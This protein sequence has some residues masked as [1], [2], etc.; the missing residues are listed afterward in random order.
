MRSIGYVASRSE[1]IGWGS[2]SFAEAY[3]PTHCRVLDYAPPP[4][5]F[6]T[7][8]IRFRH[9]ELDEDL[10]SGDSVSEKGRRE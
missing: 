6:S 10:E 4:W 7:R 9:F 5:R 8:H 1:A 2:N 3:S